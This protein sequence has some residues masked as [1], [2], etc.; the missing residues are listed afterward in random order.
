M[1]D[2]E[3]LISPEMP[4]TLYDDNDLPPNTHRLRALGGP[5]FSIW[6]LA[7]SLLLRA[8]APRGSLAE[9][10]AGWSSL[11][12]GFILGGSLLPMP[13][14]DGGSLLKWTLVARGRTEAQADLAVQR[15]SLATGAV[16]GLAGVGFAGRGKWLPAAG[17]LATAAV[18]A[19]AGLG[20]LR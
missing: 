16:A 20:K 6:G 15:T 9:E 7:T 11:G 12:H 2:D 14:V 8:I 4:R 17:L 10:L 18:A 13:I 3:I 1:Q 5:I 19:A